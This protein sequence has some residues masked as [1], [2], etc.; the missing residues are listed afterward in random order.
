M[1]DAQ[2]EAKEL[3][4]KAFDE[5]RKWSLNKW[6]DENHASKSESEKQT[7]KDALRKALMKLRGNL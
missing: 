2:K 7:I 5:P 3:A 1:F 4:Q 6:V